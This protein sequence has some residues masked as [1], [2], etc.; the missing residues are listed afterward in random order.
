MTKVEEALHRSTGR[1]V[2]QIDGN[3]ATIM[4]ESPA[5]R[6]A[7]SLAMWRQLDQ[8]VEEV[9]ADPNVRALIVR[10]AGSEAFCSGGDISEFGSI[11]S[12]AEAAKVYD[13][14]MR[15]A[16]DRLRDTPLPSIALIHG[17]CLG[18]GVALALCC[19]LRYASDISIFGVPAARLGIG[20]PSQ[21]LKKLVDVVGPAAAKEIIFTG[22]QINAE[23]AMSAGLLNAVH[24]ADQLDALVL[25][26]ARQVAA[27]APLVIRGAKAAI[28]ELSRISGTPR[29]A[30]LD[31]A[32]AACTESSDYA[33]GYQAFLEKR[34]PIFTGK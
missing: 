11:R 1:V 10:G 5:K 28:N 15:D 27:N 24:P 18:G 9:E 30:E 21:D 8:A 12:N 3:V 20:Y 33:E 19:D 7:M 26:T 6:N 17:I 25:K 22:R 34:R 2:A 32:I 13:V 29:L 4:I 14:A 16:I 23:T 31:Q